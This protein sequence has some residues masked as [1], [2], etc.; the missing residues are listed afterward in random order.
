MQHGF[1]LIERLR[2]INCNKIFNN[3]F[4]HSGG[5]SPGRRR[6]GAVNCSFCLD[7]KSNQKD[8]DWI[9]MLKKFTFR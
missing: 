8:Q 9:F 5:V 2:D 4:C 1:L 3:S 6:D 7:A